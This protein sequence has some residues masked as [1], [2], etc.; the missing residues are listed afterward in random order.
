MIQEFKTSKGEFLGVLVPDDARDICLKQDID[1]VEYYS[2]KYLDGET[3]T[4]VTLPKG[5]W[6]IVGIQTEITEEQANEI[7]DESIHTGLF[8]HYV[9]DIPVNTYCYKNA[10]ESFNS[11]MQKLEIKPDTKTLIIQKIK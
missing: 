9:K 8:A 4:W 3:N 10:F 5:T 1:V 11:L 2:D 7:V 6:K